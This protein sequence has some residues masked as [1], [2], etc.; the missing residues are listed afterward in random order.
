[1]PNPGPVATLLPADLPP[2]FSGLLATH[3][4]LLSWQEHPPIARPMS[5]TFLYGEATNTDLNIV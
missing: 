2:A 4:T 3:E 1:M 5:L